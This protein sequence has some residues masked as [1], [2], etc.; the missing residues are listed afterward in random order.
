MSLEYEPAS[1]PGDGCRE[2]GIQGFRGAG[3]GAEG[4]RGA[5]GAAGAAAH[6]ARAR[7]RGVSHTTC[8]FISFRKSNPPQ[9]RQLNVLIRNSKH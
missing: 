8:L 9:T 1:E 2:Q 3:C 5:R 4:R 6:Q 7:R